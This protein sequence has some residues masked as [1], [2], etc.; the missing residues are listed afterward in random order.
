MCFFLVLEGSG[1]TQFYV[2]AWPRSGTFLSNRHFCAFRHSPAW[3]TVYRTLNS[4]S[5]GKMCTLCPELICVHQCQPHLK[6]TLSISSKCSLDSVS[7]R[8]MPKGIETSVPQKRSAL[9]RRK[10]THKAT[11]KK[12]IIYILAMVWLKFSKFG[13]G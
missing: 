11:S 13:G 3:H 7:S 9:S 6:N 10:P 4:V 2:L 12:S 1:L 8:I 5:P